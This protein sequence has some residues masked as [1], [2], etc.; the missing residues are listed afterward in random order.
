MTPTELPLRDV[1]I[2]DAISNWPPAIG[3]WILAILIPLCCYLFIKLYQWLTR[4][5]ALKSAKNYFEALQ[6]NQQLTH[7]QSLTELSHLM[8]R[9]VI[10]LYPRAEVA[11]LTGDQWLDFLDKSMINSPFK[12]E[13]GRLL[14][15]T[16]YAKNSKKIDLTL[17]F[18]LCET[19]LK[20]QKEPKI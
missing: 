12:S 15:Q 2:P 16:L 9:T 11:S 19:W 13:S 20:A 5:T 14:T 6:Q 1:H 3:W 18:N 10:S 8:R 17:L 4:K 7:A